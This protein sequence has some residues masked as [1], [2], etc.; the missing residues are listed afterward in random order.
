MDTDFR[1]AADTRSRAD[2]QPTPSELGLP[3]LLSFRDVL[4]GPSADR[5]TPGVQWPDFDAQT[6]ARLWRRNRAVCTRPEIDGS[7]PRIVADPAMFVS[8][9]DNHFGHMV[10]ETV[11]R[12]PQS[13]AEAPDMPLYFTCD[14]PTR[15]DQTSGMFR[16][17]L[18]WLDVPLEQVRLIHEPTMFRELHVAA[19]AEYL[20]GPPPLQGY[21]DLLEARIGHKI[22]PVRPEGITFVTREGL[23]P[24]KGRHAAE[25]YLTACLKELGVRIV[26]P[27]ALPLPDQMQVY[28]SS[29]YLVFSEGSAAHGRQLLGRVDQHISILRR[30]QRSQLAMNQLEP[31]CASLSYVPSFGGSLCVAD[32][33]G[34]KILHA[35]ASLYAVAPVLAHFEALGVPLRRVWDNETYLRLR[36][37]DVLNWVKRMYRA[38]I[39]PWLKPYNTDAY[40]L[41]QF[42]PL[43][44]GHLRAKAAALIGASRP[45][46][47][48]V[49]PAGAETAPTPPPPQAPVGQAPGTDLRRS[50]IALRG[51][52]GIDL[53]ARIM[54]RGQKR[55]SFRC[56][57]T[58]VG[59]GAE[60]RL[61]LYR[62][63]LIPHIRVLTGIAAEAQNDPVLAARFSLFDPAGWPQPGAADPS[64]I[65][66]YHDFIAAW[67]VADAVAQRFLARL[68]HRPDRLLAEPGA[69][70]LG[71]GPLHDFNRLTHGVQ[72]ARLLEPV[73]SKRLD[74]R[75][76]LGEA[77]DS[78]GQTLRLL[79]DLCT[80][81]GESELARA[82]RALAARIEA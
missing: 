18:G 7:N 44:L 61:H 81:A 80:R 36:D 65:V 67:Q 62:H 1:E 31:R 72:A 9:Y 12:L 74:A 50:T 17:V 27:E 5:N 40:L 48:S 53:F 77:T 63:A 15:V 13:L 6:H 47:A 56:I 23:A 4:A 20:D 49:H 37:E 82:C 64:R 29:R 24:Q 69:L 26:H 78:T 32:E 2:R 60:A 75:Q 52:R 19:Q 34:K 46:V 54:E 59:Q 25:S 28:A 39:Q 76:P 41:D 35:M 11:P 51:E 68:E 71:I 57:A 21:L 79:D 10:A 16:S 14:R 55:P 33:R 43:G 8:M 42:E 70:A 73:L 66:Q 30:R 38:D 3:P 45:P 58:L 22:D